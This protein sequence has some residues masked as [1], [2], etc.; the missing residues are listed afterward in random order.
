LSFNRDGGG[1]RQIL[2]KALTVARGGALSI[3]SSNFLLNEHR[4]RDRTN[5]EQSDFS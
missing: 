1:S 3:P 5:P 2:K 4:A